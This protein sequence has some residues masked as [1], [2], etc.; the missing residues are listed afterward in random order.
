MTELRHS[1]QDTM[2]YVTKTGSSKYLLKKQK[3][4]ETV[5]ENWIQKCFENDLNLF[6]DALIKF[7]AK[8]AMRYWEYD[9]RYLKKKDW[10][11]LFT[12]KSPQRIIFPPNVG[13]AWVCRCL[14][15]GCDAFC[16]FFSKKKTFFAQNRNTMTTVQNT[17][18]KTKQT[19]KHTHI[20]IYM[21]YAHTK[22]VVS[23]NQYKR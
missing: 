2:D 18:L 20:C 3:E 12:L 4:Y 19:K 23:S 9:M 10:D 22:K 16:S 17:H 1:I 5:I 13:A 21:F 11:S 15:C 6:P 8:F 7:T 14:F